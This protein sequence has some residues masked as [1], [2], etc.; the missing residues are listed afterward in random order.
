MTHICE[1]GLD[2]VLKTLA[3]K[4]TLSLA[5]VTDSNVAAIADRL[6]A[7]SS[8][9]L[10]APRIVI[11]AGESNKNLKTLAEVW[12][13]MEN[14]GLHRRSVLICLGGGV[15]TD[16]GGFA[17]STFK[18]G[19]RYVNVPTTLLA[20]V[21]ASVGGKTGIDF[22]GLKN[23]I[24]A[25]ALPAAT[26]ISTQPYATLP[27]VEMMSGYAEIVKM[28][29]VADPS[30]LDMLLNPD[31]VLHD[32]VLLADAIRFAVTE[33]ERIVAEDPHDNGL[34]KTL[35]FGHTFGHAFESL[36]LERRQPVTHG[37][38]VAHGMAVALIL[39]HMIHG[40]PTDIIHRYI[41]FLRDNYG[42]LPI[43]CKDYNRLLQLMRNDKKN[44]SQHI[45]PVLISAD[46]RPIIE[47][48]S[49]E[50]LV[51]EA[52]DLWRDW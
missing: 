36:M 48:M 37:R 6:L 11:P 28:S 18:R 34:R 40:L 1:T 4:E 15:V 20:A 47:T 23:E 38:A 13:G 32:E 26:V 24:G 19:I 46:M 45:R 14:A 44:E 8:A 49:E 10:H 41:R 12:T 29:F 35:N 25:F 9:A 33:K 27:H 5:V 22:Q 7:K 2:E 16:L 42:R 43:G 39:S 52:L 3:G 31:R 17:A 30:R 50:T 21:D 51:E